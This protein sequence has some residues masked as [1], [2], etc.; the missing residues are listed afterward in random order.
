MSIQLM[1]KVLQ[2][3]EIHPTMKLFLLTLA[4]RADD[5]GGQLWPSMDYL[6]AR[7]SIKKRQA[8][9]L[10]KELKIMGVIEVLKHNRGGR[11]R[12]PHY[13]LHIEAYF[14]KGVTDDTLKRVSPTTLKGV[15]G[16]AKRVS[17][18]TP[19]TSQIHQ[20]PEAANL[21][22]VDKKKD[23]QSI[24]SIVHDAEANKA[25]QGER[26]YDPDLYD[27]EVLP[28]GWY[29]IAQSCGVADDRIYKSWGKFKN[30]TAYPY[31]RERWSRWSANERR[32]VR[33]KEDASNKDYAYG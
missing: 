22:A 18:M 4:D 5:S 28:G 14:G 11:A 9:R 23:D 12:T 19:N 32:F 25:K 2:I 30:C 24:D 8:Q 10:M 31:Q 17:P 16:D 6:A 15:M 26:G 29:D 1:S 7:A 20:E 13:L 3:K 21:K 27:G 33:E